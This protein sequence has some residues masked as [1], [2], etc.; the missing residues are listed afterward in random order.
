MK[1]CVTLYN[2]DYTWNISRLDKQVMGSG[3]NLSK[4]QIYVTFLM[5]MIN[6]FR[7]RQHHN[8]QV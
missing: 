2:V 3:W 6:S 8:P 7:A 5:K 1:W 4:C